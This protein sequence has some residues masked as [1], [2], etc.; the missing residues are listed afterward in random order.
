M[1][2]GANIGVII[3]ER[4]IRCIRIILIVLGVG[5]IDGGYNGI[6]ANDNWLGFF[7]FTITGLIMM[8]AC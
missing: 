8:V 2:C 1:N 4:S 7:G 6:P 3:N 5:C